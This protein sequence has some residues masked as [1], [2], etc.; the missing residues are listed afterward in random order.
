MTKP[1]YQIAYGA[2]AG[3]ASIATGTMHLHN[4]T[5]PKATVGTFGLY[6]SLNNLYFAVPTGSIGTL[7]YDAV[8]NNGLQTVQG[9]GTDQ[10][11]TTW[12]KGY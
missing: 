8:L 6:D 10:I 4:I 7:N 11:V 3:T 2:T 5:I 12:S 1:E 9:S